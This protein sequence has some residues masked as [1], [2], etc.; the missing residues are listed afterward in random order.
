[1]TCRTPGCPQERQFGVL[2]GG[3][4]PGQHEHV[5]AGAIAECGALGDNHRQTGLHAAANCLAMASGVGH[6]NLGGKHNN[7]QLARGRGPCAR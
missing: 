6:V 2:A 1:M 7:D 4:L 3:L 5:G